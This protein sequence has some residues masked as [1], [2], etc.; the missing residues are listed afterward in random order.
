MRYAIISDIHSNLE[1][2]SAVLSEIESLG[3]QT[4]LSLGDIVGYNASPNECIEL[5]KE[6]AI[7][8]VMGNHDECAAGITEPLNFTETA[9][10]AILWTQSELT[11]DNRSYLKQLPRMTF[12]DN[13]FTAL[14]ATVVDTSTY[15]RTED[16]AKES[17][18]LL[19]EMLPDS[20][21]NQLCFFGHTHIKGAFIMD[22]NGDVRKTNDET[23]DITDDKKLLINPGSVGQPRDLD[24]RA[25]FAVLDTD[26]AQLEFKRVAYDI[27]GTQKRILKAG[28]PKILADRLA[29][30]R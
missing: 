10:K 4:T 16:K 19:E 1:A 21:S 12:L 8:S 9:K 27:K 25:S 2:L 6:K 14:H 13:T 28:L 20:K 30:G 17:L 15:V 26:K 11:E 22:S 29:D 5:L 24:P 23:V 18:S 7:P 3:I